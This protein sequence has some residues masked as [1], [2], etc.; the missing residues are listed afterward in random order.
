MKRRR[1]NKYAAINKNALSLI[2]ALPFDIPIKCCLLWGCGMWHE[3]HI[4]LFLGVA[5]GAMFSFP[6][7][8]PTPTVTYSNFSQDF[9]L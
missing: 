8:T 7:P 3:A 1:P 5:A 2:F 9:R 4:V 6:F